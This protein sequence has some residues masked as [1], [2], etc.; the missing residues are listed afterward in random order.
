[1]RWAAP[2]ATMQGGVRAVNPMRCRIVGDANHGVIVRSCRTPSSSKVRPR[3]R[4]GGIPAL[5]WIEGERQVFPPNSP[6]LF[7]EVSLPGAGQGGRWIGNRLNARSSG[8]LQAAFG[9][10]NTDFVASRHSAG[11][12][13]SHMSAAKVYDNLVYALSINRLG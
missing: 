4:A 6:S 11:A 5:R 12:A 10:I 1:M 8:K 3:M 2:P 7:G 13:C 9:S